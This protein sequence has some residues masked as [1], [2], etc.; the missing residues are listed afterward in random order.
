[1]LE[2]ALDQQERA[3]SERPLVRREYA[4]FYGRI[5]ERLSNVNGPTVEL[6]SGIGKFKQ[7][8]SDA[9]LTDIE[10]TRWVDSVVDAEH[11]PYSDS[12]VANLVLLDVFHHLANPAQFLNEALRV[13][14]PG[15]RVTIVDPYCSPA[16]TRVYRRFHHER[17]DLSAP[18]FEHDAQTS[19]TPLESNQ[20]R[21]T[22]IFFK[23][24]DEYL[25]RWPALPVV[26]TERFALVVYPLTGGFTGPRL[27]PTPLYRPL[28][29]AERLMEPAAGLLAFRCLVV[30][31][32][33]NR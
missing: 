13:L 27:L 19:V 18:P 24:R 26:A 1:L 10:P 31:E 2:A 33:A 23:H 4:E 9:V 5:V 7:F 32:R 8:K 11:L 21:A 28:K 25:R 17:T 12:T 20:A 29:L 22:L 15:G 3:W 14:K 16:S 30:L 6:G